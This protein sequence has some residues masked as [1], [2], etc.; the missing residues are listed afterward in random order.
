MSESRES[1]VRRTQ[2]A[3]R[4]GWWPGW[5][6][7]IPLAAL[8]VVGGLGVRWLFNQ[9]EDVTITFD[10]VH[11]LKAQNSNVLYRGMKIGTVTDLSLAKDGK[12]VIVSANIDDAASKFLRSGTRF[13]LSG[14]KPSLSNLSSLTALLGGPT[15]VMDPGPGKRQT[16][17]VGLARKPLVPPG[18]EQPV[19]FSVSLPGAVG[20]LSV[21]DPVKLRGFVVGEVTAVGFHIDPQTGA[22]A[23]P[24]TLALY[25]A[26]F[27]LKN[28]EAGNDGLTAVVGR[29]VKSGLRASLERNPP[30]LGAYQVS[31]EVKSDASPAELT[32]VDG[33]R[34]IP[35]ASGGGLGDLMTRVGRI[36]IDKIAQNLLQVAQ[37]ANALVASPQLAD[38]ETQLDAALKQL[39]SVADSAGPKVTRLVASL[40]VAAEHLDGVARSANAVLGGIP[41]ENSARSAVQEITRAARSV[42]ELADYLDRHPEALIQGRSGQ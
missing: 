30:L 22:M 1:Q 2:A 18:D 38:A 27:H 14:A 32:V 35:A 10:A 17:F 7:A 3:V 34:Q 9:G 33:M 28:A 6:W 21:G 36:P 40:R 16:H 11:G 15:I 4:R 19:P 8:L 26:L 24:V 23:T 42:R 31:L 20:G 29:L 12:S 25:P 5:I 13:W 39:R 37:H 41:E